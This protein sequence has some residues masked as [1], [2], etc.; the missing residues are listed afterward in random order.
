M[1][2]S[3]S[4]LRAGRRPEPLHCRPQPGQIALR[5]QT[6]SGRSTFQIAAAQRW[7]SEDAEG[8]PLKRRVGFLALTM[9]HPPSGNAQ[10][11][12]TKNFQE[13]PDEVWL[14][15]SRAHECGT[16]RIHVRRLDPGCDLVILPFP[17]TDQKGPGREELCI[18]VSN[19]LYFNKERHGEDGS[20]KV[21]N[22]LV[23][24]VDR[25]TLEEVADIHSLSAYE[26]QRAK[27]ETRWLGPVGRRI[28][29]CA[30]RA[31]ANG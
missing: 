7:R 10:Q 4:R 31:Q 13:H 29:I 8:G 16:T 12:N 27:R 30:L 24:S 22:N 28:T 17:K 19:S 3:V 26:A 25:K 6:G 21:H 15:H 5:L 9:K 1:A 20:A 11:R 2:V 23:P 14:S 18:G